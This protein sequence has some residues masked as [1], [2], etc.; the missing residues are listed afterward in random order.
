MKLVRSWKDEHKQGF[1]RSFEVEIEAPIQIDQIRRCHDFQSSAT[2]TTTDDDD[3]NND[4]GDEF[5]I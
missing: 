4:D 5:P 1:Q 3:D 2:T